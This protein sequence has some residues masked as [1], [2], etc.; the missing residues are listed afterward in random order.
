MRRPFV[1]LT[2]A[3]AALVLPATVF[4]QNPPAQQT[5]PAQQQPAAAP[6]APKLAF[7]TN[8]GLLMVQ[9]K[10][11]QTAA[12][13]EVV[14]KMMSG[15]KTTTDETLKQQASLKVFKA[16]EAGPGGNVFYIVVADPAVPNVEYYFLDLVNKTLTPEQQR[17]PATREMYNKFVASL[18]A[19]NLLNLTPVGGG[20]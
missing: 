6:A 11:D 15:L 10:P 5:P 7:K 14:G 8:A 4:A 1:S 2:C 16:Q 18:A 3:L 19:V 13:E 9:V 20:M 17:D 12:F